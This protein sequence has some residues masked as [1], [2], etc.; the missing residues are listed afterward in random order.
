LIKWS[1]QGKELSLDLRNHASISQNKKKLK[2]PASRRKAKCDSMSI[3]IER[4]IQCPSKHFGSWK[5]PHYAK[6]ALVETDSYVL[7]VC[8]VCAPL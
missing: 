7:Y 2:I 1:Y 8:T 5:N 4:M 3:A 6:G